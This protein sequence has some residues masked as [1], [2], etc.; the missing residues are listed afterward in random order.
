MSIRKTIINAASMSSAS[1]FRLLMQFLAI[2]ILARLLSPS[3]YGIASMAMPFVI[4]ALGIA[5]AGIG[6]S[7]VRCSEQNEQEWSSSFWMTIAAGFFLTVFLAALSPLAAKALSEPEVEP[8]LACLSLVIFLQSISTIPGAK[9]QRDQRYGIIARIEVVAI[10]CS[11]GSAVLVAY[12]GG[13]AWALVTQQLVFYSIR[14]FLTISFAAFRPRLLFSLSAIRHHAEFGIS[15]LSAN[16]IGMITSSCE[17]WIIG[18][19]LGAHTI[20]TFSMSMQLCRLPIMLV[21]GPLGAPLYSHL[22][23]TNNIKHVRGTFLLLTRMMSMLVFPAMAVSAVASEPLIHTLLSQKWTEAAHIYAYMAP[24]AA[25]QT[26]VA[27]FNTVLMVVGKPKIQMRCAIEYLLVWIPSL[28]LIVN[29]GIDA[30]AI[31][32]SVVLT[33]YNIRRIVISSK[34]IGI[35]IVSYCKS[36][37]PSILI[38]ILAIYLFAISRKEMNLDDFHL[39]LLSI[40]IIIIS[41]MIGFSCDYKTIRSGFFSLMD[42]PPHDKNN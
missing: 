30:I 26:V 15:I 19:N 7:L 13:G 27:L 5:D 1:I 40:I 11:L 17:N 34:Y 42:T 2:P 9:M 29:Y 6:I 22:S 8:V 28:L 21:T 25:I 4:F 33:F 31:A 20:G 14:M 36:L 41:I 3:D 24:A 18:R 32:Y 35:S 10:C 38:S 23:Q 37:T 16:I 12:Y 39:S